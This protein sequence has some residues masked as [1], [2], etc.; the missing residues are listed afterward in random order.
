MIKPDCYKCK[1]KRNNPGDANIKCEHP[2]NKAILEN[3]ILKVMSIL[4]SVGR[5]TPTPCMGIY[6]RGNPQG[7]KGGWFNYPFS[8]DPIW[9]EECDGFEVMEVKD[10]DNCK[11]VL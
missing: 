9:L 10:G 1:W 6:V 4:A 5:V 8:F 2:K 3:P 7:I 11:S